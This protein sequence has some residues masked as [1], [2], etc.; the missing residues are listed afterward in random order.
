MSKE[1]IE[2]NQAEL[3]VC[4]EYEPETIGSTD[5][6]GAKYEPDSPE[7]IEIDSIIYQGINVIDL[8]SQ[9]DL[10]EIEA[11]V[12]DQINASRNEYDGD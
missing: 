10:E 3:T 7:S 2:W 12:W 6:W 11:R 8:F 9:D 4:F 1:Y 5:S